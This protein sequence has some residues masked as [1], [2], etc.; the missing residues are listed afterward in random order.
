M[1]LVMLKTIKILQLTLSITFIIFIN[2][3]NAMP[4]N[5]QLIRTESGHLLVP[6]KINKIESFFLVDTGATSSVLDTFLARK[7]QSTDLIPD[8]KVEGFTPGENQSDMRQFTI[9]ALSIAGRPPIR[10]TVVEQPITVMLEGIYSSPVEGILG[11]DV[12]KN[13]GLS[14]SLQEAEL[15]NLSKINN[16]QE[17]NKTHTSIPI[18]LSKIGLTY[19]NVTINDHMIGLILDSGANEIMLDVQK[20]KSLNLKGVQFPKELMAMEESGSTRQL[21]L[22]PN[23]M[24]KLGGLQIT[25]DVLLDNFSELLEQINTDDSFN[26][27]G[28]I[29]L[30][31]LG[32]MAGIIDFSQNT[33]YLKKKG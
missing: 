27:Y 19:I 24:I 4:D 11:L 30:Q 26:I 16:L 17:F 8:G 25:R 1:D 9:P 15:V 6:I 18:Y 5:I 22:A 13:M 10:A 21:G 23:V 29:G 33:L 7:L 28:V 31:Q 3:A 32:K 2:F 12:I 20:S 14:L